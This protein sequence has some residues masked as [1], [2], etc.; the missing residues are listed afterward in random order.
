MKTYTHYPHGLE[1]E[2]DVEN[3]YWLVKKDVADV[4]NEFLGTLDK[5][6]SN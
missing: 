4:V 3:G 2:K 5:K 1:E 6:Y